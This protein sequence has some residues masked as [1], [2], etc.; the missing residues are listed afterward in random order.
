[1]PTCMASSCTGAGSLSG[2]FQMQGSWSVIEL[3][4]LTE[5]ELDIGAVGSADVQQTAD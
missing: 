4:Q 2:V 3:A 1:M 5:G